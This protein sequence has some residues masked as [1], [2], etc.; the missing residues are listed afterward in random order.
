MAYSCLS[1]PLA[2]QNREPQQRVGMDPESSSTKQGEYVSSCSSRIRRA[3]TIPGMNRCAMTD[4]ERDTNETDSLKTRCFVAKAVTSSVQ[5]VYGACTPTAYTTH[6]NLTKLKSGETH[7]ISTIPYPS[8]DS[9]D[10]NE[11]IVSSIALSR[12][13]RRIISFPSIIVY[14]RDRATPSQ[15]VEQKTT[16]FQIE[17]THKNAARHTFRKPSYLSPTLFPSQRSHEKPHPRRDVLS[18]PTLPRHTSNRMNKTSI[19]SEGP[20]LRH[21]SPRTSYRS[22]SPAIRPSQQNAEREGRQVGE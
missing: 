4:L 3:A 20:S 18:V 13:T 16:P 19:T 12:R 14:S 15:F 10:V 6:V 1:S 17:Q 7:L 8:Q 21:I 2:C 22:M 5:I 9:P 11:Q